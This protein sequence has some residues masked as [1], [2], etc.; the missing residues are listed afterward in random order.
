MLT[1]AVLSLAASTPLQYPPVTI[2][3]RPTTGWN[4][5]LSAPELASM[6]GGFTLPNGVSLELGIDIQTRVNGV[7]ALH[8]VY[9]SSGPN[10]GVR[11][12]ADGTQQLPSP[13]TIQNV[14]SPGMVSS[15]VLVID[16]SPT[17]T[18][19]LPSAPTPAATVNL[20]SVDPTTWPSGAGQKEIPVTPGG[21][22]V[23]T[24]NG[25]VSLTRTDAGD[26]VTLSAPDLQVQQLVGQAT[27]IVVANTANDRVIDNVSAINVQLTGFSPQLLSSAL[28]AERLAL[29]SMGAR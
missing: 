29:D 11:V 22:P 1:I 19:I 18:T 2:Q 3:G 4:R 17:G 27:G 5:P 13:P 8:T 15:P 26:I 25:A 12:Y 7:L 24:D 6:R 16:R 23:Q 21:Q 20:L 28:V 10:V 14:S 9:A